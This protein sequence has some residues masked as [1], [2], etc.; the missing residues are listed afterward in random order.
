M[1]STRRLDIQGLRAIAVLSVL[2]FH[3]R[4][5]WLPGGFVGVD[6]F[7][8]ISGYL[9]TSHLAKEAIGT[10]RVR[11]IRFWGRRIR[12]LMPAATVVLVATAIATVVLLP[13]SQWTTVATQIVASAASVQNWVLAGSSVSYLH[14]TELP[15]PLQH[16]WSLSVEEQFYLALPLVMVAV[17]LVAARSRWRSVTALR[18]M[19]AL[20]AVASLVYSVVAST[21]IPEIAYFSTFTRA[22]ELLIGSALALW[23]PSIRP[24]IAWSRGLTLGGLAAIALSL[25]VITGTTAFP[26][27]AALLPTL[28]VAAVIAGGSGFEISRVQR[29]L[30]WRPVTWVG[31]ISY[32]L[33]LWHWPAIVFAAALLGTP[34]LSR[35]A[36]VIVAAGSVV[37]AWVSTRFVER[38][39]QTHAAGAADSNDSRSRR[40]RR[41]PLLLGGALL[42]V[43][44]LAAGLLQADLVRVVDEQRVATSDANSPG[45][46]LL[47]PAFDRSTFPDL[48]V[49]PGPDVLALQTLERQLTEEC[50]ALDG[51]VGI[52]SCD[53]GDPDGG[54]TVLLLGDSHMAMWLPAFDEI[55]ARE[56]WRVVLAAKRSCPLIRPGGPV[57]D[58]YPVTQS[59]LAWN[60]SILDFVNGL[61]PDLVVTSPM[62]YALDQPPAFVDAIV[63]DYA[64]QYEAIQAA[65]YPMVAITETPLFT[66]FSA[67][68]C[69][70]S[71]H[72]DVPACSRRMNEA[73]VV[74]PSRVGL[75]HEQDPALGVIDVTDVICPEGVCYSAI[76]NVISF[77]DD[78]HLTDPFARSLAWAVDAQLRGLAPRLYDHPSPRPPAETPDQVSSG[79]SRK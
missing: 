33:Y 23:L 28:G 51:T 46:R 44:A 65:G 66:G 7:F 63:G 79:Q 27:Y 21:A 40:I 3:L 78:N 32:S 8:V 26:G 58:G 6:I 22:W 53:A 73:R 77:R 11:L 12:R 54:R 9:I 67:A 74:E 14:A 50:L 64:R 10:G 69:L 70:S 57:G 4:P 62:W 20:L 68:D 41:H 59:C 31:D 55:G 37:V 45:A 76:G 38:A 43:S 16:F 49:A 17:V 2:V 30:E 24:T 25:V 72:P 34:T 48:P 39:F 36:V 18:V 35:R 71:S 13:L 61:H 60:A 47:D 56:H 52:A 1:S 5:G 15:S 42:A 75:V 19:I 29:A